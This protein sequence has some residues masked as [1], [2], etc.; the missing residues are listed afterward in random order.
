MRKRFTSEN[1]FSSYCGCTVLEKDTLFHWNLN[2]FS[3]NKT[4]VWQRH[5]PV[6][7][8]QSHYEGL[9]ADYSINAAGWPRM[10]KRVH[11][12]NAIVYVVKTTAGLSTVSIEVHT[13]LQH[14][15]SLP[16]NLLIN[17]SGPLV[18]ISMLQTPLGVSQSSVWALLTPFTQL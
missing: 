1:Y 10:S 12:H 5:S 4:N 9:A 6:H 14:F 7:E 2:L 13:G 18:S 11:K 8:R 3:I 17:L 16:Q 15:P